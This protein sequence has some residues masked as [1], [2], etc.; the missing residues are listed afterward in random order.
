[1]K[2]LLIIGAGG[3]GHVV[4]EIAEESGYTKVDFLDDVNP[5]SVGKISDIDRIQYNYDHCV[6]AIGNPDVREKLT[7]VITN[8]A[9]MI[10]PK[11]VISNSASISDFCV[12]EANVVI[13]TNAH[14]G[15]AS[16]V[17]AGAVVNYDAYVGSLCQIDCNAVVTSGSIVPDK[18]KIQSCSVW[19]SKSIDEC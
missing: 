5:D 2:S 12:I 14:I 6:V 18:T 17:C 8:P 9:S 3:Y 11:A 19:V 15:E 7:R 16:Y 1:M 10:H 13:N 4:K